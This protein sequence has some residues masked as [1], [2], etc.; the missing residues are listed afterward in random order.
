MSEYDIRLADFYQDWYEAHWRW[1]DASGTILEA[2]SAYDGGDD[3]A[4]L[5][6]LIDCVIEI[7]G[8]LGKLYE[9]YTYDYPRYNNMALFDIIGTF[10]DAAEPPPAYVFSMAELLQTM[11]KAESSAIKYFVGLVDAYR[12][13]VWDKPFNAEFY[14]ALAKGFEQWA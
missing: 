3:H 5:G 8:S 1:Q 7:S 14:A 2:K 9:P 6:K 11:L 13:S 4:A 10:M 12:Q